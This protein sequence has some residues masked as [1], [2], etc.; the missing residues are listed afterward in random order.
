MIVGINLSHD[1]AIATITGA[2]C[3]VRERERTSRRRHHWHWTSY[4]L[5]ILDLW[6]DDE[7]R[8]IS[9]LCLTSPSVAAIERN[10][11][12]LHSPC[13]SYSYEGPYLDIDSDVAEGTVT[14]G[15]V[16]IPTLWVSHY[17]AHAMSSWYP[18]QFENCD[19]LCLDG[20]GD[21]GYG[22]SF[23]MADGVP[24]LQE[25]LI[26]WRFGIEYHEVSKRFF[27]C[28]GFQEGK[29]MAAAAYGDSSLG[30]ISNVRD[31]NA[32]L[33]VHDIAKFQLMFVEEVLRLLDRAYFKSQKL[34]CSGGCFLNVG[35]NL[36][37]ADCGKYMEIYM[38]PYVGDMG[39][40]I[41]AAILGG[42]RKKMALPS[43]CNLDT[44][45]LGPAI[46]V[47]SGQLKTAFARY[48]LELKH[49]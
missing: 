30:N 48:G 26:D 44:A 38:P 25:R 12:I 39:T 47:S 34:V 19:C 1:Y 46:S 11:G 28:E 9:L 2:D 41:G 10:G 8:N 15:S 37:I 13:F 4:S 3:T 14:R 6:T 7:L 42:M 18:S 43:R 49:R 21:F 32:R 5:E 17:H 24:V 23:I 33:I 35:L 29:L 36:A 16:A 27:N 22:A 40:A 45:F 31:S 20:G